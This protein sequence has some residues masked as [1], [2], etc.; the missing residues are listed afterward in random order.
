[1]NKKRY[2][3]LKTNIKSFAITNEKLKEVNEILKK[4]QLSFSDLASEGLDLAIAK[5]K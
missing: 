1:M 4:A 5:Y 2:K 3:P